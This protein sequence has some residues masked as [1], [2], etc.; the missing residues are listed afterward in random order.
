MNFIQAAINRDEKPDLIQ[1]ENLINKRLRDYYD[2]I[3]AQSDALEDAKKLL[4]HLIPEYEAKKLK[5]IFRVLCK[6]LHPDLNPNQSEDEK[7][8]FVKVK[9]AYELGLLF[10]LQNILLYLDEYNTDSLLNLTP[11]NKQ[12]R[13]NHLQK[14]IDLLKEKINQLN[15]TFPFNIKDLI[16][17]DQYIV[18]K[19]QEIISKI[20]SFEEEIS[21]YSNIINIM[22]DE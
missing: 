18:N 9:T 5:E 7:D 15:Q 19:R 4:S 2:Q 13:I 11:D 1:I 6:K 22:I 10:D 3:K 14:N 12:T 21:R 20:E 8:L 16:F 17:D